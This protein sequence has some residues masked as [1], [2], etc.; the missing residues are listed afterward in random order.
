M[1]QK[2]A[3]I[4]AG[5]VGLAVTYYLS[6]QGHD[7]TV[8]DQSGIGAGASGIASGLLHPYPGKTLKRSKRADEAMAASLDLLKIAQTDEPL[9]SPGIIRKPIDEAQKHLFAEKAKEYDDLEFDGQNLKILSGVTV[10][11]KKYL[12]ALWNQCDAK[13]KIEKVETL[14]SLAFFDKIIVAAGYGVK[15]FFPDLP[16][17]F[18]K[19]QILQCKVAQEIPCSLLGDGYLA[20]SEGEYHLGSTYEHDFTSIEPDIEEAKRI[21]LP[22]AAKYIEGDIEVLGAKSGV[23]VAK[24]GDYFPI[25]EKISGKIFILTAFGSR[26][27]LYHALLAKELAFFLQNEYNI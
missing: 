24:K 7:I 10:F 20:Q 19:G 1:N 4:G 23:R 3:V 26:G 6:N 2:I 8:F 16:V 11:S 9:F 15:Q 22:R 27:L 25:S 17:N 13:L 18:N 14:E 21:I 5:F 12:E